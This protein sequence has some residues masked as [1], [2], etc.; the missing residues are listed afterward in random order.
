MKEQPIYYPFFLILLNS[1]LSVLTLSGSGL[2]RIYL[3]LA[4]LQMMNQKL[5]HIWLPLAM[6]V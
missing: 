3:I 4:W 1:V 6:V 5:M 2:K